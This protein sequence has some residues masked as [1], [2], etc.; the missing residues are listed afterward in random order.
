M[1]CAAL[2]AVLGAAF[3]AWLFQLDAAA[4]LP[5]VSDR[6]GVGGGWPPGALPDLR[7]SVVGSLL[8]PSMAIVLLGTLELLVSV[9]AD[10]SRPAMRREIVAQGCANLAGAFASAFPASASLTPLVCSRTI[11]NPTF[12]AVAARN[13]RSARSSA[14]P[15]EKPSRL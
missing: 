5:L 3:L 8:L 10:E 11:S 4:G 12:R 9:R 1:R 2:L 13:G 6:T 14:S 15:P 7:P